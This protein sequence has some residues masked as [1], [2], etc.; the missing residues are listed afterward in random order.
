MYFPNWFY[1]WF[2]AGAAGFIARRQKAAAPVDMPPDPLSVT[3][4]GILQMRFPLELKLRGDTVWSQGPQR[5]YTARRLAET[6]RRR[7]CDIAPGAGQ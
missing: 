2:Y 1:N 5:C 6:C 7:L 3:Q 4:N